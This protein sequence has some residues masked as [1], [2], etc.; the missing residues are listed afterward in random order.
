MR[1]YKKGNKSGGEYWLEAIRK[2]GIDATEYQLIELLQ[3]SYKV[4][5][6]IK[7][8]IESWRRK[9]IVCIVCSNNFEERIK[10]L[11]ERFAFL[12]DF[13]YVILSYEHHLLKPSLF[14]KINEKTG[15]KPSEVVIIDDDPSLIKEAEKM[16]FNSILYDSPENTGA[17]LQKIGKSGTMPS[18]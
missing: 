12:R 1:E 8:L 6:K 4:N 9:G 11:N 17:E 10:S 2:W 7:S 16:G 15:F 13:D 18:T 3:K 14:S 5:M